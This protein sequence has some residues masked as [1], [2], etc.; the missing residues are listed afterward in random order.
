MPARSLARLAGS[1][2]GAAA[3]ASAVAL[4]VTSAVPAS[5]PLASGP[6][7][8]YHQQAHPLTRADIYQLEH[9]TP[10]QAAR[11]DTGLN[12]V[13]NRFGFQVGLSTPGTPASSGTR[14]VSYDW[15]GGVRWDHAWVTAS[16]ANLASVGKVANRYQALYYLAGVGCTIALGG[17]GGAI[18]GEIAGGIAGLANG[19]SGIAPV[20]NHGVWA[21]YYWYGNYVTGGYWQRDRTVP[22][23]LPGAQSAF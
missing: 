13:F 16:Y 9:M 20:S 1:A 11:L 6:R 17:I 23:V 12:K 3:L 10:A 5:S 19:L 4:A 22:Q 18:C 14:L 21:A 7:L 2:I 15:S 8:P